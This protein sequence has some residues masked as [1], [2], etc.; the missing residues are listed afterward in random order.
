M[1]SMTMMRSANTTDLSTAA[2]I[3][4]LV[5]RQRRRRRQEAVMIFIEPNEKLLLVLYA[6]EQANKRASLF[7]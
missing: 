7:D 6:G 4:V 2:V 5:G 3:T 1:L